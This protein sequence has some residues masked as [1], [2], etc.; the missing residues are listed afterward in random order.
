MDKH[1]RQLVYTFFIEGPVLCAFLVAAYF[2][3]AFIAG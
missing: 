2:A 3:I 1:T